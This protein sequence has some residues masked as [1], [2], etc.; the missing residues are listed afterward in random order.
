MLFVPPGHSHHGCSGHRAHDLPGPTLFG[1]RLQ[2][3][4][5][6]ENVTV[7]K[8]MFYFFAGFLT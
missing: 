7:T 8:F 5:A 6:H 1:G 3:K 2:S 4:M